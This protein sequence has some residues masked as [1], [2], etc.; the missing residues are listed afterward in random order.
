MPEA[1]GRTQ[2]L[3][4]WEEGL[5]ERTEEPR[6]SFWQLSL[7]VWTLPASSHCLRS[8]SSFL[9][10]EN[11]PW[12]A[13]PGWWSWQWPPSKKS[14][15]Q[16]LLLTLREWNWLP[17]H[18]TGQVTPRTQHRA[19]PWRLCCPYAV[20]GHWHVA[21]TEADHCTLQNEEMLYI[22]DPEQIRDNRDPGGLIFHC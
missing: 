20:L 11:C 8:A 21:P 15:S 22:S 12:S 2:T 9:L 3:Y 7:V 6:P 18:V 5:R 17:K 14:H 4:T 16:E 10:Q 1:L 13:L 19:E